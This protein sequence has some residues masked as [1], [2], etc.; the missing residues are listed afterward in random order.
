MK[1]EIPRLIEESE[2][3][4]SLVIAIAK[5]SRDIAEQAMEDKVILQD[6]AVNMA[7]DE[8]GAHKLCVVEGAAEADEPCCEA[9][10][11]ACEEENEETEPAEETADEE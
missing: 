10:C 7:I 11:G 4:Y 1:P 8:F 5:R 6:K 9:C 3:T 2:S